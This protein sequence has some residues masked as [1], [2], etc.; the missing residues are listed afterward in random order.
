LLSPNGAALAHSRRLLHQTRP[1]IERLADR[2]PEK[3][4]IIG[5]GLTQVYA[6][7]RRAFADA[8]DKQAPVAFHEWR[9]E[10]KYLRYA[11]ERLDPLWS[12]V[13]GAV[14]DQ[15]HK[16]ADYLGDEHDLT[17]LRDTALAS[18]DSFRDDATLPTL[19]ALID[20]CQAALR[21]RA[22]YVGLR[23]YEEKP[24]AFAARFGQYWKVSCNERTNASYKRA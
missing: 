16:L 24:K 13:I 18:R 15:A 10:V 4:Q 8:R 9:K 7:G 21:E 19:L 14:A 2:D 23:L 1:R 12:G 22:T 11:L 20:R 3:W 17:V 6:K 5:P